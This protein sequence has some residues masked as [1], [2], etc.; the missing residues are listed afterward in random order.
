VLE[1]VVASWEGTELPQAERAVTL[2]DKFKQLL[3]PNC[4][5]VKQHELLLKLS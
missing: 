3:E 5:T 4:E 1:D 2:A